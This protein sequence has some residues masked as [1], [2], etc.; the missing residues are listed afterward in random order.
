MQARLCPSLLDQSPISTPTPHQALQP[1]RNGVTRSVHLGLFQGRCL[2]GWPV[3]CKTILWRL[4]QSCLSLP[5][6]EPWWA[7]LAKKEHGLEAM[8]WRPQTLH[9]WQCMSF[10]QY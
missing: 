10:P 3:M 9:P 1:Q 7:L 8:A 2:S 4:G 5:S 6:Q